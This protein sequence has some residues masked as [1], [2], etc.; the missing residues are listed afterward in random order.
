MKTFIM[1]LSL[2]VLIFSFGCN[3]SSVLGSGDEP[4]NVGDTPMMVANSLMELSSANK[5]SINAAESLPSDGNVLKVFDLCY[6]DVSSEVFSVGILST[7][8]AIFDENLGN[9]RYQDTGLKVPDYSLKYLSCDGGIVSVS[10]EEGV[11]LFDAIK[12]KEIG[13]I[14]AESKKEIMSVEVLSD[15]NLVAVANSAG[16]Q[17]FYDL[18]SLEKVH[19]LKYERAMFFVD[20][21]ELI[22][23]ELDKSG[24]ALS[25]YRYDSNT[26]K[27]L[28]AFTWDFNFSVMHFDY[29]VERQLVYVLDREG[30]VFSVSLENEKERPL[31]LGDANYKDID[32]M[33]VQ[34]D[35][36]FLI[37]TNGFDQD[38]DGN[39]FGGVYEFDLNSKEVGE[40]PFPFKHHFADFNQEKGF[41]YLVNN[42]GNSISQIDL[43]DYSIMRTSLV[44]TSAE[45]G[46]WTKNGALVVASRLGGSYLYVYDSKLDYFTTI[47]SGAWPVSTYYDSKNDRIL[48]YD[49]LASDISVFDG[50][51]FEKIDTLSLGVP[52]GAS[53]A[54]G[55]MSYDESS[56]MAYVSIPEQGVVIVYDLDAKKTLQTVQVPNYTKE[57]MD[58]LEGPGNLLAFGD[59]VRNQL[60]IL[61]ASSNNMYVYG[62]SGKDAKLID[63]IDITKKATDLKTYLLGVGIDLEQGLL[64][65]G[66]QPFDLDSLSFESKS[67]YGA[68]FVAYDSVRDVTI[69]S[70]LDGDQEMIYLQDASGSLID[71]ISLGNKEF[72][73]SRFAYDQTSGVLAAFHMVSS[74]VDVIPLFNEN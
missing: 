21:D 32:S 14:D 22:V 68:N 61:D 39:F 51:T 62:L 3:K 25:Y 19:T 72:V 47:D 20:G 13:T 38:D 36:L 49:F 54:L 17:V 11:W 23:F 31:R 2:F 4:L 37:S 67:K 27:Q 29:D 1:V 58:T 40:Y 43:K 35:K 6:D 59:P 10:A 28:F 45:Q 15:L 41:M 24:K 60:I 66:G 12:D 48:S 30:P 73:L 9:L 50:T 57:Y 33:Y 74:T 53:D 46:I 55:Y 7:D 26:F 70:G 56:Q 18:T 63:T 34:G 8:L 52:D 64:W 16:E 5:I 42:D 65:I 44:G 71:S 69:F